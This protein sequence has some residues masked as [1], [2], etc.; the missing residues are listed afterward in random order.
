MMRRWALG[1]GHIIGS[2]GVCC[3]RTMLDDRFVN[4]SRVC[5]DVAREIGR[6]GRHAVGRPPQLKLALK[7]M[8]AVTM[9]EHGSDKPCE[10]RQARRI[11]MKR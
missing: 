10:R 4:I 11:L 7:T 5:G 1:I 2:H 9:P 8:E 6:A 3:V